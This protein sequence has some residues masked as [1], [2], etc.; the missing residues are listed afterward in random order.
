MIGEHAT[1]VLNT[2]DGAQPFDLTIRHHLDGGYQALAIVP[3]GALL[4]GEAKGTPAEAFADLAARIWDYTAQ[5]CQHK[6]ID[7]EYM[8]PLKATDPYTMA[9]REAVMRRTSGCHHIDFSRMN[10]P[11]R[12]P[13]WH[14][15]ADEE[16]RHAFLRAHGMP[17]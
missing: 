6:R 4:I 11:A 15:I 2:Q 8:E 12:G 17:G 10:D 14:Q 13:K 1:V 7:D 16:E 5:T 9:R 3:N